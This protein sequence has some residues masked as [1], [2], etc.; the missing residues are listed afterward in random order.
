MKVITSERV[1][2]HQHDLDNLQGPIYSKEV[3]NVRH[4]FSDGFGNISKQEPKV[5]DKQKIN[6]QVELRRVCFRDEDPRKTI[7]EINAER[8]DMIEK[9]VRKIQEESTK[10][11]ERYL[12]E[13]RKREESIKRERDSQNEMERKNKEIMEKSFAER[14]EKERRRKEELARQQELISGQFVQKVQEQRRRESFAKMEAEHKEKLLQTEVTKVEFSPKEY[15]ARLEE[16]KMIEKAHMEEKRIQDE[17]RKKE[18]GR[19]EQDQRILLQQQQKMAQIKGS[20]TG[21][22]QSNFRKGGIKMPDVR[23]FGFGNVRTGQVTTRKLNFLRSASVDRYDQVGR[24]SLNPEMG[25]SPVPNNN[26]IIDNNSQPIARF[27]TAKSEARTVSFNTDPVQSW[28]NAI[29]DH[30]IQ[31]GDGTHS[32]ISIP[33]ADTTLMGG[34]QQT[35][36]ITQTQRFQTFSSSSSTTVGGGGSGPLSSSSQY[37]D[38]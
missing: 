32:P 14:A 26:N 30:A 2:T 15:K 28:T 35:S 1:K 38:L 13:S 5:V 19:L 34:R 7:Q 12:E 3:R 23:S 4:H 29:I 24:D 36:V 22:T 16:K 33:G 20:S 9:E 37:T 11:M 25:S 10:M 21:G 18:L 8:D 27:R 6:K 17:R 31:R